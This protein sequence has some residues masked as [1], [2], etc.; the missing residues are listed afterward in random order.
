MSD[1]FHLSRR[2]RYLAS[3]GLLHVAL[4][5][6]IIAQ[7]SVSTS[8]LASIAVGQVVPPPIYGPVSIIG[9]LLCFVIPFTRPIARRLRYKRFGFGLLAALLAARVVAHVYA[10]I[11]GLSGATATGLQGGAQINPL[12]QVA[13]ATVYSIVVYVHLLI[14]GWPEP[15][16]ITEQSRYDQDPIRFTE[17]VFAIMADRLLTEHERGERDRRALE[18]ELTEIAQYGRILTQDERL[19][20]AHDPEGR[21]RG[22]RNLQAGERAA[23]HEGE[24]TD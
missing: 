19:T 9:G 18:T 6:A 17:D 12:Q 4:G 16:R 3:F 24:E 10:A 15:P 1:E 13:T 14:A 21:S 23:L 11:V 22:R 2:G 8:D 20:Q 5:F 7:A